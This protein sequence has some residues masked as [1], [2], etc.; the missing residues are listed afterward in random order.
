MTKNRRVFNVTRGFSLKRSRAERA[1]LEC[2][3]EW[4]EYGVSIRSLTLA[5]SI[6][7]R[8]E[9]ARLREPLAFAEVFGLRYDPCPTGT[10]ATRRESLLIREAREFAMVSASELALA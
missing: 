6:A 9:Q 8:N 10:E 4:V 1:I 7:A 5:E 3:A 2:S